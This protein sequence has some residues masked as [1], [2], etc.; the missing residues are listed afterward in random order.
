MNNIGDQ[1][2]ST[3]ARIDYFSDEIAKFKSIIDDLEFTKIK[4]ICQQ[5]ANQDLKMDQH[6]E[7]L[8]DLQRKWA[9]NQKYQQ[10]QLATKKEVQ[11]LKDLLKTF[12]QEGKLKQQLRTNETKSNDQLSRRGTL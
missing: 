6:Q 5:H 1:I 4:K 8:A 9:I 11:D 3:K 2:H 10:D 7:T 12:V